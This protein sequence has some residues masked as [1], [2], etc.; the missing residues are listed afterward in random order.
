MK[1]CSEPFFEAGLLKSK[2]S[3][4]VIIVWIYPFMQSSLSGPKLFLGHLSTEQ[5]KKIMSIIFVG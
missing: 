1:S 3:R 5:L 2:G 4:P